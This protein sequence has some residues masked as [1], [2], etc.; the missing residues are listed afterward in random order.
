[1]LIKFF[2]IIYLAVLLFLS[3]YLKLF[4]CN[5][6]FQLSKN[7]FSILVSIMLPIFNKIIYLNRSI[8]S[9]QNQSFRDLEIVC[10]DDC[11][12]DQSSDYIIKLMKE[13]FRIKLVQNYYNQGTCLTRINGVLSS[14]GDYIISLDPDDFLYSDGV[15]MVYNSAVK[16][17]ADV[18][19]Y[20]IERRHPTRRILKNWYPCS[21]NYTS[22]EE[23]LTKLQKFKY[24]LVG[25]SLIKK[26][27]KKTIYQQAMALLLPFV[28][29][30]KILN[31]EDL[32]HCGTIF[33]FMKK[34]LCTQ[35]LA[36]VYFMNNQGSATSGKSQSFIQ[37]SIQ[38]QYV[39]AVVRYFYK[40]RNN[41]QYCNLESLLK[42]KTVLNLYNNITNVNKTLIKNCNININ[43]LSAFNFDQNG[44]CVIMKT[45]MKEKLNIQS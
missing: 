27:I 8:S 11:S 41:L 7:Q 4:F 32:L 6:N 44:Y 12:S 20:R 22:N 16:L 35:I 45:I 26:I 39:E 36:Y 21:Q 13:D 43:E 10:V 30:K 23:I 2:S 38:S 31:A 19:E 3:E 29:G 28:E 17:D 40:E 9:V 18:L 34:F 14:V 37:S 24:R 25:W 1:M 42:N 5:I 15:E 33:L